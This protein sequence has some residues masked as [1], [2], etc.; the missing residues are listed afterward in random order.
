MAKRM[1]S[2]YVHEL[3][4][5]G[6]FSK[7]DT[8][9]KGGGEV[10]SRKA[11]QLA[12]ISLDTAYKY[13]EEIGKKYHKKT[14]MNPKRAGTDVLKG[15]KKLQVPKQEKGIPDAVKEHAGKADVIIQEVE[16]VTMKML[17]W[18]NKK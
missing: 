1:G 14:V 18:W 5:L 6:K 2:E 12:D 8:F 4:T 9:L 11:T 7:V 15:D 13:I 10:I 17:E 3:W 16:E